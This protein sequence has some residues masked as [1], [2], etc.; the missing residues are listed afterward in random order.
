MSLRLMRLSLMSATFLK[1]TCPSATL[2]LQLSV[3]CGRRMVMLSGSQLT[4]QP[5]GSCSDASRTMRQRKGSTA[6]LTRFVVS[7]GLQMGS[8]PGFMSTNSSLPVARSDFVSVSVPLSFAHV[9]AWALSAVAAHSQRST[10]R[11]CKLVL[12]LR[13]VHSAFS[14]ATSSL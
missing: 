6:S 4:P 14:L 9:A 2:K 5:C 7:M 13:F 11:R 3:P 8:P 12:S 1:T 10:C